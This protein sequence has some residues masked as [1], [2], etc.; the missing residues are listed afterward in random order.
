MRL[1][2]AITLA[3]LTI[4]ACTTLHVDHLSVAGGSTVTIRADKTVIVTTDAS[5]PAGALGL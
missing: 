2:L 3:L 4:S 1:L 5:I